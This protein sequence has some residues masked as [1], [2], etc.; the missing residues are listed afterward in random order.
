MFEFYKVTLFLIPQAFFNLPRPK[1]RNGLTFLICDNFFGIHGSQTPSVKYDQPIGMQ[2]V[3]PRQRLT[4]YVCPY[5]LS[6]KIM[7]KFSELLI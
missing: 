1:T 4:N 5:Q 6:E 7:N 3:R 2:K